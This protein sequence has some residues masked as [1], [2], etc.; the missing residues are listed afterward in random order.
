MAD[1]KDLSR[2]VLAH[3]DIVKTI[4]SFIPATK[5][6]RN[7]WAICPFHDDTHASMSISPEKRMFR[8]FVC[9]VSGSEANF[10]QRYEHISYFEALKKVAE[11]NGYQ[12]ERL[13]NKVNVKPID[14]K[15]EPL[16]KCLS[17]L[18][19]YYQYALNT[20]EGK[21]GLDYFESRNLD[22]KLR[23]KY[24]LGYAFKDGKA[25]CRFLQSKGHSVKTIEDVGI[26]SLSG[27]EYT[28]RNQGR[29]IFPIAD[30]DGNV[31]GY[32]ARRIGNSDEAKY[33]NS[34]ETYLFYKSN[35]LYNFHIAKDKARTAGYIYVLE[36]FM[37]V[38]ALGKIGIDSAVAIMGTTLTKEHITM[39]RSLNV[40]IR[41]C[42]DGDL[43]GQ[44]AMM[45]ISKAL[46]DAGL[47]VRVVD[48]Q[49]SPKDPDEILNE[50]G[51]DA[52]R[53]Y[54]NNLISRVDFALNYFK[55]SN[56]LTTTN[57]KKA[58][59]KQFIPILL[60]INSQL[61]LDS[62]LRKLASVT[63]FEAESIRELLKDARNK[64]EY[65][66]PVDA[67]KDF[68]PERKAMR[69]LELAERELLYQMLNNSEAVSFYE[70]KIGT[71]YDEIYRQVANYIV[72]YAKIN[73]EL[74]T[75]DIISSLEMSDLDNKDELINELTKISFEN[76]HNKKCTNALLDGLLQSIDEEKE[77]IFEKDTLEQSLVGKDPLEKARIMAEYNRRKMR[78]MQKESEKKDEGK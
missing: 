36:G 60:G 4:T 31:V 61:E 47:E 13:V 7:Y 43:A 34:P 5:K 17:D 21:V 2:D 16:L 33:V 30:A 64:A 71:F 51:P 14:S 56:P 70:Q 35:I 22:E 59:I 52:L 72:D 69:K 42:L 76:T 15:K 48:N 44:T 29:V 57:Q 77:R 1:L 66:N 38:F 74:S 65:D 8:C 28:D 20:E 53:A 26:A 50:D 75:I 11:I 18:T 24:K 73:D 23:Y 12:D 39:L 49:N 67:I 37:D 78:K 68:H 58:L 40:E 45:N 55:N 25:T 3:S 41:L 27:G 10:I 63:G 46:H 9:G 62:Y 19:L 6:G 32:S 54:L